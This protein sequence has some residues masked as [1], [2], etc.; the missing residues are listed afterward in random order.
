MLLPCCKNYY[1]MKFF[2]NLKNDKEFE[3]C[4]HSLKFSFDKKVA[5]CIIHYA[6]YT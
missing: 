6:L 2:Q 1:Q 3:N 4:F 5:L